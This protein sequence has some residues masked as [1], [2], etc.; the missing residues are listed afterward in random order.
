MSKSTQEL[1]RPIWEV[2]AEIGARVPAKEWAK[3]P[4][5]LSERLDHYLYGA[6]KNEE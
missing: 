5:D 1:T 2:L 6:P 3:V 4:R